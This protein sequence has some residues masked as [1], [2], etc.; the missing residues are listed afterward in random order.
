MVPGDM[1][2]FYDPLNRVA[3]YI[4]GA[5]ADFN[6]SNGQVTGEKQCKLIE[7]A[8][9]DNDYLIILKISEE[10]VAQGIHKKIIC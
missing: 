2:M 9:A 3:D 1:K 10:G 4:C 5:I 8:I 7:D 6:D